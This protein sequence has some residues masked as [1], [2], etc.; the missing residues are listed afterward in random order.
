MKVRTLLLLAI[1]VTFGI[2]GAAQAPKPAAAT[3]IERAKL[4]RSAR[5][6]TNQFRSALMDRTMPFRV[7]LPS[8]YGRKEKAVRRYPVLYLLHG[9]FGHFDN[10]TSLTDIE[11][12]SAAMELIIVM[13]EGGDGWYTDSVSDPSDKYESY[14]IRELIPEI[15]RKYRTLARREKRA[16]AGLSMGGYGSIKFGLK[17][18]E[19]FSLSG[20]LSGAVDGPLRGQEHEHWRPSIMSVF[21]ADDNPIRREND[22]FRLIRETDPAKRLPF[23]YLD[24]GTED[25]INFQNNR[26]L[27]GLMIEKRIQHE[28][29]E[30]PG[31]HDWKYW[32]KQVQE[33]LRVADKALKTARKNER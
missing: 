5:T 7:I 29:R 9:L 15:D 25:S 2:A 20:S 13:P 17:Y 4:A 1:V 14:I 30:L 10:W 28:Y 6:T 31:A 18:P 16:I 8:G 19:L 3:L 24:C 26:D 32:D 22:V 27:A 21:G 33:F 12:Y 23:F 11:A